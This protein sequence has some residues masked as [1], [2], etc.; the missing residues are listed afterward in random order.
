MKIWNDFVAVTVSLLVGHWL[1]GI[2]SI[3]LI[4]SVGLA[5]V[6]ACFTVAHVL[7]RKAARDERVTARMQAAWFCI[8][9]L[10]STG[11]LLA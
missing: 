10:F 5:P 3:F 2:G 7:Q 6:L 1:I 9:G 4:L 11:L 8:A